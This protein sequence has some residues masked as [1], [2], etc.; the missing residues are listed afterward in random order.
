MSKADSVKQKIVKTSLERY[1]IS[2]PGNSLLGRQRAAMTRRNSTNDSSWEDYF[3]A[4]LIELKINYKKRYK[5]SR[6]PFYCD[7]YLPDS[8]TFIEIQ[9]YWAH[10][11]HFYDSTNEAD[12]YILDKWKAKANKGHRQYKAAIS[13][14]TIRDP[15]K[16]KYAI[17]N[18]LNYIT[19]WTFDEMTTFLNNLKCM[20]G[21]T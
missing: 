21:T 2:N 20:E 12:R 13:T 15:Q 17:D 11:K 8:D 6:Y 14:W 16:L 7:F 5:E 1:G 10:N 3:E 19:L 18:N 4:A 9:G